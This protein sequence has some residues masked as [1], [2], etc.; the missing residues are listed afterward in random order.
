[1]TLSGGGRPAVRQ[2][3]F[4]IPPV[5]IGLLVLLA[6]IHVGRTYLLSDA[7]AIWVLANFAFFPQLPTEAL[8][9]GEILAGARAWS[10]VTYALLHADWGH[11]LVNGFWMAAFGSPLAWRFGPVRF[12]L[13]STAAAIAG[14]LVHLFAHGGEVIPMVGA[15]A[16]VSAH[17][18]GAGR[19]LF[20]ATP[21]SRRSYWAP[22]ATL[23]AVLRDSRTMTFL[24]VWIAINVAI[25]LFGS[26]GVGE[27]QI[28]WE[29]H[30]G[31]FAVGLF[32]FRAFDPVPWSTDRPGPWG[33]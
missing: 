14:A 10:F 3:I 11:L 28:A 33:E 9:A 12:L 15:S 27:G 2:P 24:G 13:F 23:P 19:F 6:A 29:A 26:A 17:L 22:A 16:A 25:G 18:A 30:L 20:I 21:G 1:M 5:I 31:G 32:L 7:D 8:P 4:N